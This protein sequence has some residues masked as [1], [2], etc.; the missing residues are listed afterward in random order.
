MFVAVFVCVPIVGSSVYVA[1]HAD[2][3][4]V[5]LFPFVLF[6]VFVDIVPS[7][8]VCFVLV[9]VYAQVTK[10]SMRGKENEI[11]PASVVESEF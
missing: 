5:V 1:V 11:K 4:A 9:S 7:F 8:V 2:L 10:L 6:A 3:V